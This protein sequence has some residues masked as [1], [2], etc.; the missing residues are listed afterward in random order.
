MAKKLKRVEGVTSR[1]RVSRREAREC[2]DPGPKPPAPR[3]NDR[4]KVE[5]R[6]GKAAKRARAPQETRVRKG[7]GA[8]GTRRAAGAKA[9]G[10]A[11]GRERPADSAKKPR[12]M[13]KAGAP[14]ASGRGWLRRAASPKAVVPAILFAVF[15]ALSA[16]PVAGNLEA[17]SRLRA[18]E[19]EL[20]R[21]R[22]TTKSLQ[23]EMAQARSM[24]YIEREARRQ[25]LVAPGEVLILVTTDSEGPEVQYRLKA[26]QSM[27]EAWERVRQMLHCTAGRHVDGQ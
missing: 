24:E 8:P 16:S 9:G 18:M 2:A 4:G 21:E 7:G 17:Q 20:E 25:R 5:A 3:E 26:L 1:K 19:R 6:R 22:K 15:I 23:R 27:D 12:A 13:E 14:A 11:A 10:G